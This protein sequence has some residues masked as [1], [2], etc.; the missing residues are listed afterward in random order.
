MRLCG[1]PPSGSVWHRRLGELCRWGIEQR[2]LFKE[3]HGRDHLSLRLILIEDNCIVEP[4]GS[5]L[6]GGTETRWFAPWL[7]RRL[8]DFPSAVPDFLQVC[9]QSC[10]TDN[11]VT[12]HIY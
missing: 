3:Y 9:H 8:I 1:E 7:A 5:G 10:N 2:M 6:V 11:L 4:G 12:H